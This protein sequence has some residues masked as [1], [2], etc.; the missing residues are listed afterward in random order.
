MH[1]FSSSLIRVLMMKNKQKQCGAIRAS[2]LPISLIKKVFPPLFR[3][4][5][6]TSKIALFSVP[7]ARAGGK[8]ILAP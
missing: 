7:G 3:A 6:R 1:L 4:N 2:H 5:Y 8:H